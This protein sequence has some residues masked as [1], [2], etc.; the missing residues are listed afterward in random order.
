M[1][2]RFAALSFTVTNMETTLNDLRH[3]P[4][5]WLGPPERQAWGGI[6]AHF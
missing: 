4:I 1:V 5:Q 2:G 6:L 3:R